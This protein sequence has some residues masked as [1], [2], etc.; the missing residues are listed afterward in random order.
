MSKKSSLPKKVKRLI[1]EMVAR[2]CANTGETPAQ[3]AKH[4]AR[5]LKHGATRNKPAR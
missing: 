2:R 3:A 1:D 5:Y 4:I